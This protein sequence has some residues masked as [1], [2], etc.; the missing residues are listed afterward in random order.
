[1]CTHTHAHVHAHAAHRLSYR[2]HR[3]TSIC[4]RFTLIQT[5]G[6]C[7]SH[8]Y[9]LRTYTQNCVGILIHGAHRYA[10]IMLTHTY[11]WRRRHLHVLLQTQHMLYTQTPHT[12]HDTHTCTHSWPRHTIHG[13]HNLQGRTL[14]TTDTEY[15]QCTAH[16][17]HHNID[18][19][20]NTYQSHRTH[21]ACAEDKHF[22]QN[23]SMAHKQQIQRHNTYKE[24]A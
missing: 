3:H 15:T 9:T 22:M 17:E 11:K 21:T 7:G 5:R 23:T 2:W 8:I 6:V 18:S 16:A 1:M 13:T 14:K 12:T 19:T 24:H 20:R 10:H 4:T